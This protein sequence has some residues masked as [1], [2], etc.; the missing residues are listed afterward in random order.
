MNLTLISSGICNLSCEFCF[1]HK[2]QSYKSFDKIV[3]KAWQEKTY[4]PT[5]EKVLEKININF[6]DIDTIT[7]WGGEPLLNIQNIIDSIPEFYSLF[8]KLNTWMMSTNFNINIDNLVKFFITLD[9]YAKPN[10][11]IK[12]QISIDGPEQFQKI[13]HNVSDDIY[14]QNFTNLL[15][16]LNIIKLNNILI[17]FFFKAVVDEK[18][19]L[20]YFSD[21]NNMQEYFDYFISLEKFV[22]DLII[23][24]NISIGPICPF[25][26][27]TMPSNYT[28]EQ[29]IQFQ[30]IFKIW[31]YLAI[32]NNYFIY[33]FY[34]GISHLVKNTSLI[35]PNA[36]CSEMLG[37]YTI[38]PDGTIAHCGSCFINSYQEY[39]KELENE[40]NIS[41][42]D[43]AHFDNYLTYNPLKMT[44]QELSRQ[45]WYSSKGMRNNFSTYYCLM[46]GLCNELALSGQISN[47]Y[48]NNKELLLRHLALLRTN[49]SCTRENVRNT[50]LPYINNVENYRKYF[51]GFAEFVEDNEKQK[52]IMYEEQYKNERTKY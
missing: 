36:E 26:T 37:N 30:N 33:N 34:D 39:Q 25:P 5:V 46:L 2:N 45:Q 27:P 6:Q 14:K 9:K 47:K 49:S 21:S 4:L 11:N 19:Y 43:F 24:K 52:M 51:N 32:K 23:N 15:K 29:S 44:E 48:I 13:G 28:V 40:N 10:T 18:K 35:H 3:Q 41:Y 31:N 7:L 8:P 42:L 1:L 20:E 16:Q 22:N 17:N 12:L 50:H 38:L